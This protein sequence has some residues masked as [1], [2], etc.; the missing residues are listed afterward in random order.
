MGAGRLLPVQLRGYTNIQKR[1]P[2]HVC[3]LNLGLLIPGLTAVGTPRSL[4]GRGL[5]PSNPRNPSGAATG[6]SHRPLRPS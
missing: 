4:Q 5:A 2:V 3:G 1:L 6:D